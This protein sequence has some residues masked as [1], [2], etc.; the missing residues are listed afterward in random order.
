ADAVLSEEFCDSTA[1][2]ITARGVAEA[3]R[4][5]LKRGTDIQQGEQVAAKGEKLS[6]PLI[7]LLASAGSDQAFVYRLPKVAVIA[8]GNEVVAP[9]EP[10][11][12]GKL[13]ASN[14]VEI[15]SWLAYYGLSYS[16]V[17]V[18]DNASEIQSAI[19]S[20]LSEADV[21]ITSGG[22]WGSE[23]DLMLDVVEKMGWQGIYRRVRMGPGKPIGFGLLEQKPF[24]ILPGGPPSNE[25]AFLQLALPAIMKMKGEA[26]FSFPVAR[27]QLAETV[28]G[29]KDWTQF[30]HA[31]LKADKHQLMVTPAKLKSR[32][33]SMARK[34]ALIIIPEGWEEWI[35]GEI[36]DIQLLNPDFN[37]S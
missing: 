25:M 12:D 13:Y 31:R 30:I 15:G 22:A 17:L 36:I 7:G 21:F 4:N 35:A 34:D 33:I 28:R 14:M 3:G 9:G 27:A 18:A 29:H 32:L 10:L 26:A 11:S 6:P 23:H 37:Y 19:A 16:A 5:L 1:D 2:T 8:S 20:R 24:F